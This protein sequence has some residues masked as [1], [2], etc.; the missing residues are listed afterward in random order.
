M[1]TVLSGTEYVLNTAIDFYLIMCPMIY[2]WGNLR[3]GGLQVWPKSTYYFL[4]IS[5]DMFE[6]GQDLHSF[7]K[8]ALFQ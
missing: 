8:G 1:Q 2:A 5:M 7:A 4:W 6:M 3:A